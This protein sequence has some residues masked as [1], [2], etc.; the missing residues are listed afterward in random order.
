[1]LFVSKVVFLWVIDITFNS[2]VE[3][4]GFVSLMIIIVAM[5]IVKE[6]L[7]AVDKRLS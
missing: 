1:M 6:S 5:T 4:S 7:V 2:D 3:V